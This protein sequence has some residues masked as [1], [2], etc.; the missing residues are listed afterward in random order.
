[1]LTFFLA[2]LA[3]SGLPY[4]LQAEG[5]W[6]FQDARIG[7][8]FVQQD[9]TTCGGSVVGADLVLT[10][11]HCVTKLDT[12]ETISPDQV[13]FSHTL[14]DGTSKVYK[15]TDIATDPDFVRESVP[16]RKHIAR[17]VAF[18]RL[19]ENIPGA[20]ED[21]AAFDPEQ[22]Y[23]ALLP[24][25]ADAAFSGEPCPAEYENEK[26]VVLSCERAKG[27][28]GMPAYSLIDGKRKIVAVISASGSQDDQ[29]V[30]FAVNPLRNISSV[31]WTKTDE[32]TPTSY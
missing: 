11:A 20:A 16:S 13:T 1:M 25:E 30:T 29:S 28:S 7:Q 18:L 2:G 17:D 23:V 12:S 22:P 26:I 8:V 31:Q 10:A 14:P 4:A 3:I 24:S 6:N 19:S 21:M 9:H 27:S 32:A 15:V 5:A